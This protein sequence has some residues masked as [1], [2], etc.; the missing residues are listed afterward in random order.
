VIEAA[1]ES[2][3][4]V[5]SA[6]LTLPPKTNGLHVVDREGRKVFVRERTRSASPGQ[7][8]TL[9]TRRKREKAAFG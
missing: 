7:R 1:D 9:W 2:A 6:N 8:L 3:A 4:L 5:A